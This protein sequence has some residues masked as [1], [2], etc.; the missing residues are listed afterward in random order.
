MFLLELLIGDFPGIRRDMGPPVSNH[1]NADK[2]REK[3]LVANQS[4]DLLKME[5]TLWSRPG[6]SDGKKPAVF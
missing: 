4:R 5:S 1:S 2:F 6:I 3:H